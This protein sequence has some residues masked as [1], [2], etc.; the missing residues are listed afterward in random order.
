VDFLRQVCKQNGFVVK[1][2]QTLFT[3]ATLRF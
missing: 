3:I 1:Q 2:F